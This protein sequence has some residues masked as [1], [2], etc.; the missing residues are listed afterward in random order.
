MSQ[1]IK[2]FA[3]LATSQQRRDALTI[4]EAGLQAIDT[5]TVLEDSISLE[6][7]TMIIQDRQFDLGEYEHIYIIGFG[8]VACTAA[9]TLEQIFEGRVREG[10]VIGITERVC[11]VVDTYSGTHPLPSQQNY[12][13]TK[14]IEEVARRAKKDDLVLVIVSGGGSALLCS[15]MGECDQG[16]RLFESFLQS[17]GT[18]EELNTVRKHISHLKGGGLAKSLYPATVVGLVF[19]DVPGGDIA[20]VASGPTCFDS[21]TVH[22][23]EALID[24]YNLGEFRLIETPKDPKYFERVHNFTIVSNVTA[25]NAMQKAAVELSYRA[26]LVS[27]NLYATTEETKKLLQAQSADGLVRCMGGETKVLVPENCEGKGGRN[28]YL[29]LSMLESLASNQVFISIA[30]DG[31]DNTEMAGAIADAEVMH[32]ARQL[33]LSVDGHMKNFD[34]YPFF[35][36][37][38]AQIQTGPLESNVS[39]LMVLL[40]AQTETS[41]ATIT[42]VTAQVIKD[43][44]GTPTISVTVTAGEHVGVFSVPGGASTGEHEVAVLPATQAV[45]VLNSVLKPALLGMDVTNQVAVD[46]LLHELDGTKQFTHIG[47]NLALGVSVAVCKTAAAVKGMETWQYVAE[48]FEYQEQATAPRLFVNLINGGK[49]AKVGSPIQEHQII[50]D[51][52]NVHEALVAA[53]AVQSALREVLSTYYTAQ[54]ITVGDEGG[55]VIPST[56]IFEPFMYIKEAIAQTDTDVPLLIGTDIAASSFYKDGVYQLS[57]TS[58][59]PEEL[60]QV[61][62]ELHKS[63]PMLQMV[64]DPYDEH[65]FASFAA[66]HKAHPGVLAIGD[67]LTTTNKTRLQQAVDDNAVSALIIK[68][69][70]IGTLSD[71]LETMSLAYENKVWCIVSHRSGETEDD[72]IAD[73]AF[74]T[75]CYGLKA[76]A[77]SMSQRAAKYNRL[78]RIQSK[79]TL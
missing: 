45:K 33:G 26:D 63:F 68:P 13:A 42:D 75:K 1:I 31:R 12:T 77:P 6:G 76:G 70:Q 79:P 46:A 59:T 50:P 3:A 15:S 22:E 16:T 58:Y 27:A 73:L 51:T 41:N 56:T 17:G 57:N 53:K 40:T 67:D 55:F 62:H 60:L 38:D 23:A 44:R 2:N 4:V 54:Q 18:I 5:T 19:S 74:G 47:G 64:E 10:A 21:S 9:L 24:K 48:L 35:V 43:S 30:S 72:F 78:L 39:D 7:D 71:T 29:A 20:A 32:R 11:Q 25:L 34:S 36:Q 8:K 52:T 65:D 28:G 37:V 61:Y 14:H 69:N 66:Y 49:H